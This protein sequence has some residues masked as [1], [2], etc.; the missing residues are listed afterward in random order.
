MST[1][2]G[3]KHRQFGGLA[4]G[5]SLLPHFTLCHS[6]FDY[7][8]FGGIRALF[9]HIHVN[10]TDHSLYTAG[11]V[12]PNSGNLL[13]FQ[14]ITRWTDAMSFVCGGVYSYRVG[15]ENAPNELRLMKHIWTWKHAGNPISRICWNHQKFIW[16]WSKSAESTVI[17]KVLGSI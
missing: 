11:Y 6:H 7:G 10:R 17:D 15:R 12:M 1:A 16:G 5:A 8:L 3:H 9:L 13:E 14:L 2:W 4:V